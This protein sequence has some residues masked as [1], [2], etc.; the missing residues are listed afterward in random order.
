MN[1]T[2]LGV[3]GP[4]FLNQVPTLNQP[5]PGKQPHLMKTA[6][7][8]LQGAAAFALA[9]A[10][11]FPQVQLGGSWDLARAVLSALVWGDQYF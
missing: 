11:T 4:G 2:F 10:Q 3:I 9:R 7:R 1:P 6:R 5:P 8:C